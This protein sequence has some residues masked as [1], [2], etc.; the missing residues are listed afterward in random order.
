MAD[1]E[2]LRLIKHGP[3]VWNDW[4]EKNKEIQP[5]LGRADLS[6][7]NLRGI[8]LKGATLIGA[9]LRGASLIEADL[10]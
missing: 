9:N 2:H 6:R 4:R 7:T 3:A 10:N 1:S 5:D 8:D